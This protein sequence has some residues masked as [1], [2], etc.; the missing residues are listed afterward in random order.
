MSFW[1]RPFWT[2]R[3]PIRPMCAYTTP[4]A[5]KFPTR[6]AFAANWTLRRNTSPVTTANSTRAVEGTTSLVAC[7]LG[8]QP[9]E[10]NEVVLSTSG[11]NFRRLADVEGSADGEQWAS[12]ASQAILFRFSAGGRTVEQESISYPASRYRYLRVRVRADPQVDHAAPEISRS[13]GVLRARFTPRRRKQGALPR[14]WQRG[15]RSRPAA[16]PNQ[17]PAWR[18][19]FTLPAFLCKVWSSRSGTARFRARSNSRSSTTRP[20]P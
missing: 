8:A 12:L 7:D 13:L 14:H 17:P 3:A 2:R 15:S 18:I 10:H 9:V 5:K 20:L 4:R 11:N 19:R 6:C 1:M 16:G